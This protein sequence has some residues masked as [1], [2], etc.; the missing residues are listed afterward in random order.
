MGDFVPNDFS[1]QDDSKYFDANNVTPSLAIVGMGLRLPGDI[2]SAESLWELLMQKKDTQC[3][4]PADRYNIDGFYSPSSKPGC[5]GVQHGHF[6]SEND[7]LQYMDTSF[8]KMSKAEVESLDPQQRMLLEVVWECMESSGQVGWRGTNIGCFVGVWGGDWQEIMMRDPQR[9]GRFCIPGSGDFAVSNRISY[10]YDL[11]GPSMTLKT[12]CSSSLIALHQACEAIHSG[13]CSSALVAGTNLIITPGMT[14]DMTRQ[15]VLSPDGTCKT[16]DASADGYS[17]GEAINVIYIKKLSD[18]IHDGDPIRAVIRATASNCDGKTGGM[19]VP[20]LESHEAMIRHAYKIAGI[21]DYSS[22]AFVECHGT[23]TAVG[24]PLEVGAI[25]NVFGGHKGVYIGSV[26]PNVGHSEGA[27]GLTS[28]IKA[29]LALERKI[30]PPNINFCTPNPKIPFEEAN[31]RVPTEPIPWPAGF[32]ERVSVNSFGIGGANAHVILDSASSLGAGYS[33]TPQEVAPFNSR[34]R[35]ELLLFSANNTDSLRKITAD[36]ERYGDLQGTKLRDLAYTLSVRREHLSHRS[37]CV[38]NGNKALEPVVVAKPKTTSQLVFVFTGQGAQWVGMGKEL[39]LDFPSF[40]EDMRQ[41]SRVLRKLPILPTPW[42]IEDV[43]LQTGDVCQLS[44]AEFS[45]P[46]CSAIQIGLVNLLMKLGISPSAVTGHSSG[47][48]AAAFAANAITA[49]EAI[50]I[51]FYRGQVAKKINR[52]GKMVSVGLGR[53]DLDPYIS[54]G[55]TIACENSPT[56]VTLSGNPEKVDE[57]VERLQADHPGVF[58]RQLPVTV[59]YHSPHMQEI[60]EEYETLLKGHVQSTTP[61]VPFFSSVTGTIVTAAGELGSSYWRQNLESPVLFSTAVKNCMESQSDA[62]LFLEIGPHSALSG[63]LRQIFQAAQ[64]QHQPSYVSL[65]VRSKDCT[66]SL[67]SA[68]GRLYAHSISVDFAALYAEGEVLKG[69][70]LYRWRHDTAYWNEG[71]VSRD[72]RLRKFVHH[73]LLGSR[74]LEGNDLEPTWRNVLA[75]EN[76]PWLRD[77]RIIDDIV[78]PCAGYLAIVAEALRQL[79]QTEDFTFRDIVVMTALVLHEDNDAELMTSLKPMRL[80]KTLDSSWY[81]FAVSSY[82]RGTWTKHCVGQVKPGGASD[83]VERQITT[84]PRSVPPPYTALKKIGLN[85]GPVFQGLTDISALPGTEVAVAAV[86]VPQPSESSYCLHPSTI[87]HC[88]QLVAIAKSGGLLRNINRLCVPTGIDNLY[89][90]AGKK[91]AGWRAEAT[92]SKSGAG[93]IIG[94]TMLVEDNRILLSLAGGEFSLMDGLEESKYYDPA[95]EARLVWYPDYDLCDASNLIRPRG[96]NVRAYFKDTEKYAWIALIEVQERLLNIPLGS[97]H[98]ENFRAWIDNEI[99]RAQQTPPDYWQEILPLDGRGRRVLMDETKNRISHE[100]F[101]SLSQLIESVVDNCCGLFEGSVDPLDILMVNNNLTNFYALS[102]TRFDRENFFAAMGISNTRLRILEIGAGTGGLTSQ[103]LSSLTSPE[104]EQMFATYTYTDISSGFFA[105]AKIRFSAYK[106]ITF[107]VLD[108]TKDATQQG[109]RAGDYDLIIASNVLHATPSLAQT[110]ENVRKLMHPQGKL[111]LEE[112]LPTTNF[113][114][115]IF[116]I[117]PGWWLGENDGRFGGPRLSPH[118][119]GEELSKAGFSTI[120]S[121]T[122]DEAPYEVNANIVAGL[123]AVEVQNTPVTLLHHLDGLSSCG[124]YLK[125]LLIARGYTV[126]LC[127]QGETPPTGQ[128]II[129]LIQLDDPWPYSFS[130]DGFAKFKS[131]VSHIKTEGILWVMKSAQMGCPDPRESMTLGLARTIRSEL[132]IPFATLELDSTDN[133]AL[134]QVLKVFVKFNNRDETSEMNPD[135]EYC[136]FEKEVYVSRYTRV[137]VSDELSKTWSENQPLHL[138]IKRCGL[139]QTLGWVP[140]SPAILGDE[141]VLIEPRC[142][143]L[144]FRDVLASM[145]LIGSAALTLGLE[146]SGLVRQVGANVKPLRVGDRVIMM[147][148]SC[149]ATHVTVSAK[150]CLKIPDS[151]S[152]EEAATMPCVFGTV[153]HA[154]IEKAALQENQTV[155]IHSACG[156]IGLAAI[157]VC[158][159]LG[160]KIYVTVGSDEKAQYLMDAFG[161]SRTSIFNSRDKTF[162]RDLMR[163]TSNRGVDVVLNSLSGELLHESWKCVAEYGKMIEIG[164]RD[165]VGGAQL[166]M[167]LF[168]ANRTFIGVDLARFTPEMY[169]PL[170]A[171]VIDMYQNG[172]IRPIAVSRIFDA[173]EVEGAFRYMQKGS[174]IGKILVKMPH[175]LNT[176]PMTPT[177]QDLEL[178]SDASYLL[179]GGLGG[180]G[181]QVSTWMVEHGARHLIFLSRSAGESAE[182][183]AFL[184]ELKIQGC[185]AQAIA[186]SVENPQVVGR[187]VEMATQPLAGI[188]HMPMVIRDR[189]FDAMTYEDWTLAVGAKVTGTWNLHNASKK[190]NLDFFVLFASLSGALGSPGQANYAAANTFLDAFVQYRHQQGLPASAIDLGLMGEIGFVSK[191]SKLVSLL[192]NRGWFSIDE[193][194]LLQ[195]LHL[196]MTKT[197]P[198]GLC[199]DESRQG[200]ISASQFFIGV[201]RSSKAS[202]R[203]GNKMFWELDRRLSLLFNGD[204]EVFKA[205]TGSDD[206]LMLFISSIEEGLTPVD[207]EQSRQFLTNAIGVQIYQFMTQPVEDVNPS[208]SLKSL[209]VDSLITIEIRNWWRRNLGIEISVLEILDAGTIEALGEFAIQRLRAKVQDKDRKRMDDYLITKLP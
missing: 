101:N 111:F 112:G 18:A 87:D 30:I 106:N 10:E 152:W 122:D 193:N 209:G 73:E 15:G 195:T 14:I 77:H 8:F 124:D 39:L 21:K 3:T 88:L 114:G 138:S 143:G 48:I 173:S 197:L 150:H 96:H 166:S 109:F 59:A 158:Q 40:A 116:G 99:S 81:D 154:L 203:P 86:T 12:G 46:L 204:A 47:E 187:A 159:M 31:L 131:L 161:I 201:F 148:D 127:S 132:K 200:Y 121:V 172:L 157:Q 4:I 32:S 19:S 16:F 184:H 125:Q 80:T 142:V 38:T 115:L 136:L 97:G 63:P 9:T 45:Q 149:F 69:L 139:L 42:N 128:P 60:G 202:F 34:T 78:F 84:L 126:D 66:E 160:A 192:Q 179:V 54:D 79:T 129:S 198:R 107:A 145:G 71:R 194:D 5:V 65:L 75:M 55:I 181:R 169:Q 171:K 36:F 168:E 29:V 105:P 25:A 134:E 61:S 206:K 76:V 74:I 137:S 72:W 64:M 141:D 56:S 93:S 13:S 37:F 57:I 1:C 140:Y 162:R 180:I 82:N 205:S 51:A 58:L 70:P 167:N 41:L 155:L 118:G 24:D 183:Q 90:C 165:F 135:Y 85:Y 153:V 98:L 102:E 104:G 178:R 100:S 6:L 95:S 50:K 163:E 43:L 170:M 196:S 2:H 20:S 89:M 92:V 49:E 44:D 182:D 22:T 177:V 176:I 199:F 185:C 186:G 174:H 117:L 26:K 208:I 188:I 17:R 151:L 7:G 83:V 175:D 130:E 68:V 164:K 191:S 28:I 119:W 113:I 123:S 103:V 27:S 190:C 144:N 53:A 110:F 11:K 23:G 94:D 108:I 146:C 62:Q 52:P 33:D 120:T 91:L 35:P 147:S 67:L 133:Y 207:N 189:T 156:G